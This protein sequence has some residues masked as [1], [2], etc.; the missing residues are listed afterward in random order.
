M[1]TRGNKPWHGNRKEIVVVVV[2]VVVVSDTIIGRINKRLDYMNL[3]SKIVGVTTK[4]LY[5]IRLLLLLL[6]L[7]LPPHL[8]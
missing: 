3:N 7:L 8:L 6:L 5:I 1:T 4:V 2:V